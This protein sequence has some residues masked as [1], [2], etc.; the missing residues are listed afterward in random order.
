MAPH[1]SSPATTTG[2]ASE[3]PKAPRF[4]F[5]A[6]WAKFSVH[7]DGERQHVA[8]ESLRERLGDLSGKSFLDAG[9][10]SGLFS[11]AAAQLG[12]GP[13]HSFDFDQDSVTTTLSLRERFAT[14]APN[15]KIERGDV[16]DAAY[17]ES[18]GQ[19]DVVYSWGVLHHTG[20]M[21]RGWENIASTVAPGGRLF[22]SIYN[23]QGP[24]SRVW[25]AVKRTYR[26]VPPS[27]RA[28]YVIAAMAPR[29]SL[30]LIAD[31]PS[32]YFG[33]WRD[34][35]RNRGMSR[36]HDLVDWVGGWPFEVATPEQVFSY[37][38]GLGFDLEWML[39]CGGGLGCNQFVFRRGYYG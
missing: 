9:C 19:W 7:V 20:D 36:W 32:A 25:T 31:G 4:D 38:H 6:N 11:L 2:S 15:W 26:R 34:Y 28:A 22:I 21:R 24:M 35:K 1:V 39:T 16:L 3:A 5:G 33:G 10:G 14:D 8:A 27:L 23:D 12:A 37:F 18:L 30:S 17:L 13:I 29:E